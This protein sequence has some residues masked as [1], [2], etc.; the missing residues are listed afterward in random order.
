MKV[1]QILSISLLLMFS[2]TANAAR[3][4]A[5]EPEIIC[6]GLFRIGWTYMEKVAEVKPGESD[7]HTALWIAAGM[8]ESSTEKS[9]CKD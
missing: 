7:I 8:L 3:D 1:Y 4:L 6:A 9:L 5:K 2:Y